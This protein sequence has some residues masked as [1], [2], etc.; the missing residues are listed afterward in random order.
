[1]KILL[2]SIATL[3]IGMIIIWPQINTQ[4]GDTIRKAT[5]NNSL[6]NKTDL[7]TLRMV[8]G[9]YF[10]T[11]DKNQPYTITYK[12]AKETKPGSRTVQ[13]SEPRAK[14]EMKNGYNITASAESG[15]Y[16]HSKDELVL[17]GDVLLNHDE[18]HSIASK[19]IVIQLKK[20]IAKSDN[21]IIAK[22]K[23]GEMKAQGFIADKN[24]KTITFKGKASLVLNTE[25]FN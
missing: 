16:Y 5:S 14:L 24:K 4:T 23:F 3:F 17:T 18:G 8:E 25:T 19:E 2:P 1:M 13:L 12:E 22:G 20:G 10:S 11:D 6:S 21:P 15:M 7:E 9:R